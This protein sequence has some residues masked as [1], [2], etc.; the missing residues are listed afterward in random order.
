MYNLFSTGILNIDAAA[1]DR[2]LSEVERD[3]PPDNRVVCRSISGMYFGHFILAINICTTDYAWSWLQAS[4]SPLRLYLARKLGVI[5]PYGTQHEKKCYS[6]DLAWVK[7]YN[8]FVFMNNEFLSL[9]RY[10][11]NKG[12]HLRTVMHDNNLKDSCELRW[13]QNACRKLLLLIP[14]QG[15]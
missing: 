8:Y 13:G 11:M 6:G 15:A 5:P 7:S 3:N 2:A 4:H 1:D 9:L 10:P 14:P 12:L